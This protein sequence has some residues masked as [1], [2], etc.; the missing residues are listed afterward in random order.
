MAV[1]PGAFLTNVEL[2]VAEVEPPGGCV[3]NKAGATVLAEVIGAV[4][5]VRPG[6]CMLV[7]T[8]VFILVEPIGV[9]VAV[10][11][12]GAFWTEMVVFGFK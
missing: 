7:G 6:L 5:A 10:K 9:G 11:L 1:E 8:V 2:F 12:P 4:V 3:F